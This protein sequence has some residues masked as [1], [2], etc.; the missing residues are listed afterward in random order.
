M[1]Y[2]SCPQRSRNL[3]EH[4]Y[5]PSPSH[6]IAMRPLSSPTSSKVEDQ[7]LVRKDD[8]SFFDRGTVSLTRVYFNLNPFESLKLGSQLL[9]L[10]DK[11]ETRKNDKEEKKKMSRG[12]STTIKSQTTTA[13]RKGG[14]PRKG[15]TKSR[16]SN[17]KTA[18]NSGVSLL[19]AFIFPPIRG[20]QGIKRGRPRKAKTS[21]D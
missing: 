4:A 1:G 17:T 14:S 8:V 2:K 16:K 11:K 10:D 20:S 6:W 9:S 19:S 12:K 5:I 15:I 21:D 13:K 18:A 3:L 7:L